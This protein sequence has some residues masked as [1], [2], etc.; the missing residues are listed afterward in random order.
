MTTNMALSV[1]CAADLI[2]RD[3]SNGCIKKYHSFQSSVSYS[4]WKVPLSEP[5]P[6]LPKP[7]F[8]SSKNLNHETQVTTLANGLRVA[9]QNKFGQSCTVGVVIDSGSRYEVSY[10]SGISHFLEK[11]AFNSTVEF[12]DKNAI[13]QE[14]ERHGG[15]CDCQGSRDTLIYAASANSKSLDPVVSLLAEAVLRPRLLNEEIDNA[16]QTI[17]FELE[18]IEMRQ[19]QEQLMMELIHKAAY[20]NNTLGLPK[21]CPPENVFKIDRTV[22]YTYLK[23]HFTPSRMVIAGVG[24]EHEALMEA[25]QKYFVEKHPIWEM[26]KLAADQDL[27]ID[28]SLSQYTGGLVKM[29]KDMASISFGPSPMPELAYFTLGLESCSHQHSDFISFCVLNTLMGGGGSFSA[30]GPGKGMYTRLYTNVLNRY[31]WM[32]SATAFNHAYSDSGLFCILASAPPAKLRELADVIVNEFKNMTGQITHTELE[33]AK[34]QLQSILFMNLESRPV[35]FEDIG[36]QV[37]A[38]GKRKEPEYFIQ[39]IAKITSE[40]IHNI[41]SRM[42][43]SKASVAVLGDLKHL[44]S[45]KEIDA[46]L[47]NNEKSKA[48]RFSLFS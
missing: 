33:R 29:E 13:L 17:Q 20:N 3:I 1:K 42:L 10:P 2:R 45:L 37:L 12:D 39:E 21:F 22:L 32:Y 31:H 19:E 16:R 40:D 44:P 41:S 46:N 23:N 8:A 7:V 25:C 15:I 30:G 34:S 35:M 28:N 14:L 38:T 18:D 26:E 11:L 6:S 27:P 4:S 9:S 24:I 36:R 43:K 5:L 48:K 47:V